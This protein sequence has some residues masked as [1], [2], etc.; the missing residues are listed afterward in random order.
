MKAFEVF[1]GVTCVCADGYVRN[2]KDKC[3]KIVI[4]PICGKYEVYNP[5]IKACVCVPGCQRING[6]CI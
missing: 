2:N 5:T 6:V 4:P 1:N 3:V